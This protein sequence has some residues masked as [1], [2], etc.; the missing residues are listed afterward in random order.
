[1]WPTVPSLV[2]QAALAAV[3]LAFVGLSGVGHEWY[4]SADRIA[5]GKVWLLLTS[6]LN[7]VV[8]LD[9]VQW[10][11]LA[12]ATVAVIYRLGPRV[13]WITA[14]TG[15]VVSALISYAAIEIAVE[16]GSGSAAASAREADY[17]VSIVL[18][19]SLGALTESGLLAGERN[20]EGRDLGDRI[21]I[22]CGLIGLAGMVAVSFGWYDSQH[23]IGYA[24]GFFMTRWMVRRKK[25]GI[26]GDG[27][28]E[29][30]R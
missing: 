6:S 27:T 16:L 3:Y 1:M 10:F 30:L 2:A 28:F 17:G 15:H 22:A 23:L 19:A 14:L 26:A 9:T 20:P 18:A 21:S 11:L 8:E 7:V 5:E 4:A 12:A 29:R 25:W 24:I 13:W